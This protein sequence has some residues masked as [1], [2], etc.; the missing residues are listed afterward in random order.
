MIKIIYRAAYGEKNM[1]ELLFRA[2]FEDVDK[3]T[4]DFKSEEPASIWR[5]VC[6]C[7]PW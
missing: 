3:D 6:C 4:I 1:A 7:S 2:G 5:P